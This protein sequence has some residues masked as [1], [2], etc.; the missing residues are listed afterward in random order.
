VRTAKQLKGLIFV[1]SGPSGSGKSTL[2]KRLL[3]N[4]AIRQKVAKSV[5]YTTRR[6]RSGERERKDY[7]FL[8][9]QD[10]KAKKRKKLILECTRY[11]GYDYATP[12]DFVEGKLKAG[13]H[14]ILCLDFRG[15]RRVKRFY[16]KN[17]VTV[18]ILPPSLDVLQERI[19]GRCRRTKKE[20][21]IRRL[22]LAEKELLAFEWYDYCLVNKNLA[23]AAE[24]LKEIV[25]N[26]IAC[27]S[28]DRAGRR[29][30]TG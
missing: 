20:E 13:K 8:T 18:F 27:L 26:K 4:K 12:R 24:E 16:P 28:A 6:K 22:R 21:I 9:P 14:I 19:E 7:F 15:A 3:R 11:L 1:V 29:G 5:S 30:K 2:L 10:F 25:L 23:R 17:T